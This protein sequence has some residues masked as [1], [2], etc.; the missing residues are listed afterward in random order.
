MSFSGITYLKKENV[1][2]F[3]NG[4]CGANYDWLT[5]AQ[6]TTGSRAL[7]QTISYSSGGS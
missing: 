2:S 3:M 4:A 6:D 1:T 7:R 5:H